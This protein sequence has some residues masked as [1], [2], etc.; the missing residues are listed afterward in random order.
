MRKILAFGA[1]N[2]KASINQQFAQ[3]AANQVEDAE[4]LFLHLNDFE[5]PIYS[6]DREKE[7]GFPQLAQD[8]V[9]LINEADGIVIFF[10]EYNGSFTSDFKNIYDW[11]SRIEK[12]I[13]KNKPMM[14]LAT[15]PGARGGTRILSHVESLFP[16]T[17]A[18][19][20]GVFSLPSFAANFDEGITDDTLRLEF[21]KQLQI[22]EEALS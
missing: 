18:T 3:W 16:R 14:I 15:S 10:A 12:P 8:F 20:A 7:S 4:T 11:I 2:S 22:F 13:W 9:A 19:L 6:I 17:G 1:S 21:Q 5:M